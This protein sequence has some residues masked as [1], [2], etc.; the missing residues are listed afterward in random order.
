MNVKL[1][2]NSDFL[3]I[4]AYNTQIYPNKFY[5]NLELVTATEDLNQQNIAFERLKLMVGEV[6]AY[7]LFIN[8]DNPL[9]ATLS[10]IHADKLVI[11]PEVAFDQVIGIALYCK[12]NA[13][14]ESRM[15]CSQVRISS[16]FGDRVWYQYQT[17]EELGPFAVATPKAT[18]GRKPTQ[19]WWHRPDLFTFDTADAVQA[20]NWQD[21]DLGWEAQ[22]Q[23]TTPA[24]II[25]LARQRKTRKTQ[26]EVLPGGRKHEGE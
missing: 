20:W 22:D 10:K 4:C 7:G 19:P 26:T 11:L 6:F 14:M 2:W 5:L 12:L 23:P 18:R 24:T 9:V 16:E 8:H 1:E 17:G 15:R 25:D 3:G 21:F 13:I